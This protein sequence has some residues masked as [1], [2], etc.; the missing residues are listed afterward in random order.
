MTLRFQHVVSPNPANPKHAI[1][2]WAGK[3]EKGTDGCIEA[4]I[5][6]FMQL[7]GTAPEQHD[8]IVDV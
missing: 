3:S 6:P 1:D 5:C 8:P 7:G 4:E 2:P